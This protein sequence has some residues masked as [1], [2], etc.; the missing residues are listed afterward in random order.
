MLFEVV[1]VTASPSDAAPAHMLER[2]LGHGDDPRGGLFAD[3]EIA[4]TGEYW[5]PAG[6]PLDPAC[7]YE[8]TRTGRYVRVPLSA[9]RTPRAL[10]ALFGFGAQLGVAAAAG[11]RA[12]AAGRPTACVLVLGSSVDDLGD[13]FRVYAGVAIRLEE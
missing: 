1:W 4:R 10:A 6:D 12:H 9:Y 3:T 11:V 8:V 2:P 7:P 13:C 5:V